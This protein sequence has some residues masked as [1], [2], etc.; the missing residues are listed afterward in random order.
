[1]LNWASAIIVQNLLLVSLF[2]FVPAIGRVVQ[3]NGLGSINTFIYWLLE[4]PVEGARVLFLLLL[5]GNGKIISGLGLIISIFRISKE[6]W[7]LV[8]STIVNSFKFYS[9]EL[10]VT[11]LAF[12]FMAI[13]LNYLIKYTAGNE[14]LLSGLQQF[15]PL[16]SFN[17]LSLTLFL[18][19]LTIIPLT[20]MFE[21]WLVL[22]LVN[23]I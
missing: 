6:Q 23:R 12:I 19:N 2:I 16:K 4:I 11:T 20:L 14:E 13:A 17:S 8:A 9:T 21:I 18:K 7:K 15:S 5:V 1:M 3:T 10:I 22:R